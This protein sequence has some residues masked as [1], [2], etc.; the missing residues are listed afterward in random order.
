MKNDSRLV[1]AAPLCCCCYSFVPCTSLAACERQK[2]RIICS[3]FNRFST[4]LSEDSVF[5]AIVFPPFCQKAVK[6]T[7]ETDRPFKRFDLSVYTKT[8]QN[9]TITLNCHIPY[10][11]VHTQY[12]CTHV[13]TH[14]HVHTRYACTHVHT[15]THTCTHTHARTHTHKCTNASTNVH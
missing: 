11:H 4:V 6:Q 14:T 2:Q 5:Y 10:T 7:N 12:T 15:H 8:K 9:D 13:H 1:A 3:L